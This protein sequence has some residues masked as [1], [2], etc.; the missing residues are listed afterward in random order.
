ME[1]QS[2]LKWYQKPI[3]VILFLIF[4]FPVGIFLMWK[5]DLWSK[6]TR[7]LVSV[8]FGL[9]VVSNMNKN[10]DLAQS[11][12]VESSLTNQ[13]VCSESRHLDYVR[14]HFEKKGNDVYGISTAVIN[15]CGYVFIV[16][17]YS[18]RIGTGYTCTVKTNGSNGIEVI[19]AA[20]DYNNY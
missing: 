17:G 7:A 18:R 19:D 14:E 8:F 9:M 12:S 15:D 6:T 4:F 16:N 1:N 10:T 3:T 11:G 13:R 20:C 5:Y 2:T